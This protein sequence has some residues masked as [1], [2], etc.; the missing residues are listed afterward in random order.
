[1]K[2]NLIL[3]QD[4]TIGNIQRCCQGVVHIHIFHKGISLRFT[5]EAYLQ[6]A[7]MIKE[8]A[9]VLMGENLADLIKNPETNVWKIESL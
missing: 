6:F 2:R 7:S 8:G 9:S 5:E 3:A 1:M 4:K